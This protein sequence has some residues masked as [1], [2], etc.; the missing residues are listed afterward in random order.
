MLQQFTRTQEA[1]LQQVT[2]SSRQVK[3]KKPQAASIT[4]YACGK[5][6]LHARK[7]PHSSKQ[8]N[9]TGSTV[10]GSHSVKPNLGAKLMLVCLCQERHTI[11]LSRLEVHKK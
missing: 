10:N 8:K 1:I 3:T 4:C 7:C 2:M 11:F 5:K 9:D 6:G